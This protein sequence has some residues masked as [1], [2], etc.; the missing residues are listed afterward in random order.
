MRDLQETSYRRYNPRECICEAEKNPQTLR[1]GLCRRCEKRAG[2]MK[3]SML[4]D[5][6]IRTVGIKDLTRQMMSIPLVMMSLTQKLWWI[7]VSI[8]T[9]QYGMIMA[10]HGTTEV[11]CKTKIVGEN[12][13]N[14]QE[15]DLKDDGR[16]RPKLLRR[17]WINTLN[18]LR[19]TNEVVNPRG[20]PDVEV[21]WNHGSSKRERK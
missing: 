5:G 13:G 6:S 9:I 8:M 19:R 7:M 11:T 14:N 15:V 18:I 17:I 20:S 2:D 3:G 21:N 1:C 10:K 4:H 16:T 12:L